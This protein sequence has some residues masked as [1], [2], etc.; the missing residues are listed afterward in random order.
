MFATSRDES[1]SSSLHNEHGTR[2]LPAAK[3][4][5]ATPAI[6]MYNSSTVPSQLLI[7]VHPVTAPICE[8]PGPLGMKRSHFK[9]LILNRNP[10]LDIRHDLSVSLVLLLCIRRS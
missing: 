2:G 6:N 4:I 8:E 9:V 5:S 1:L 7:A 10:R 3:A